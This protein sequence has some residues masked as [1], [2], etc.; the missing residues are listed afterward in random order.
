MTHDVQDQPSRRG[1]VSWS[2]GATARDVAALAGVSTQTVSR[3]ANGAQ[4]VSPDTRQRVQDAMATLGYAPNAAARM[5]KAGRSDT[6]GVVAH[7][8]SRTGEAHIV[9]AVCSTARS[10]G[11]NILLTDAGSGSVEETNHAILQSRRGV[12][13]LVV[14]G[15][16]TREVE[17][18]RFPR[19]LPLVMADSRPLSVPGVGF[20]QV[21]GARLAVEH[22]LGLGRRTVHLVAGPLES[23]QSQQREAGWREALAAA[24]RPA[25][26]PMYGDWSPASG[27]RIG[28]ELAGD[29]AVEAIFVGNDEM[30]SGVLRALHE[31][32]RRIPD[33][34]AV[35]GFDDISAECLWPPLTSVHQDFR[36]VGEGLV[37][38][39]VEQ[40]EGRDGSR[41]VTAVQ[42]RL[43]PARLVVRE[44]SAARRQPSMV[45]DPSRRGEVA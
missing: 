4:N 14:L 22:L 34:V 23:V 12:A 24:G 20:D 27:Y 3:V 32:G 17:R 42:S 25:P 43:V 31:A 1:G 8:L 28:K 44:S 6:I 21:G 16:E 2:Q 11:Y 18:L 37:Q 7:H 39:L 19:N 5:L 36:A 15:L 9:E 35:V 13:G 40:I 38:L 10:R 33:D 29:P 26:Q 45:P 41:H 30:A